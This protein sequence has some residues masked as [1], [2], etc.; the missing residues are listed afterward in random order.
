MTEEE[1]LRLEMVTTLCFADRTHSQLL[2]MI[3][4]ESTVTIITTSIIITL[5]SRGRKALQ[6]EHKPC[7]LEN[8]K[9]TQQIVLVKNLYIKFDWKTNQNDGV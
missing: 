9:R 7:P 5:A 6:I 4:F 1:I 8:P 3:S 2:Y